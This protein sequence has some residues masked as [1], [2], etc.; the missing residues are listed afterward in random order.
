VARRV[1]KLVRWWAG[2]LCVASLVVRFVRFVGGCV[3]AAVANVV[4]RVVGS[5]VVKRGVGCGWA[6]EGRVAG[7]W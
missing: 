2:E 4:V 3:V 7:K 1:V 5:G 6:G